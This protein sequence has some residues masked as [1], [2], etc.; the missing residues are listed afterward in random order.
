MELLPSST[1][2]TEAKVLVGEGSGEVW[3]VSRHEF[4]EVA[5]HSQYDNHFKLPIITC[6]LSSRSVLPSV[7][8]CPA[9][10]S[11]RSQNDSAFSAPIDLTK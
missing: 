5:I 11:A 9:H 6:T 10:R 2:Y 7:R 8:T 4:H 3:V 1:N